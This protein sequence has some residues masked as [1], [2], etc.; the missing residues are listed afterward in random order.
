MG[1]ILVL[2]ANATAKTSLDAINEQIF[3]VLVE[4][5]DVQTNS[6]SR[7]TWVWIDEARLAGPLLKSDLLPTLAVK[8]R[9]RGVALVLAFQDIEGL[10]EAAGERI[11]NELVAPTFE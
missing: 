6:E 8:G 10:R 9:S 3:R 5:I 2:G 1:S 7:R 4:E 11:A